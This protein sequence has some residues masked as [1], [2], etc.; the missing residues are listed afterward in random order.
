VSTHKFND[1]GYINVPRSPRERP[2]SSP[3]LHIHSHLRYT[4]T[5]SLQSRKDK[6]DQIYGAF[7]VGRIPPHQKNE[8]IFLSS[9][10]P[11][12][13]SRPVKFILPG[14]LLG[15]ILASCR[16]R[17]ALS[18]SGAIVRKYPPI[19]VLGAHNDKQ[20]GVQAAIVGRLAPEGGQKDVG[21]QGIH[22]LRL[23]HFRGC[24]KIC[25]AV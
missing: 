1:V 21:E 10:T 6:P 15:G 13:Y 3:P 25:S 17:G 16:A 20:G 23:S 2:S 11:S 18:I 19:L 7:Q 9:Q 24:P 4:Q 5:P 8:N 14:R 12:C 22:N